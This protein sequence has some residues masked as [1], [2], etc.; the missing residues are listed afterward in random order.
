MN[1]M[2]FWYL[3]SVNVIRRNGSEQI[4]WSSRYAKMEVSRMRKNIL[5]E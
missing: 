2:E 4:F 1:V 5:V 3:D